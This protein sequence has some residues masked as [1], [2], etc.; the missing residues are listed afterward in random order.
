MYDNMGS[1]VFT[2]ACCSGSIGENNVDE[3]VEDKFNIRSSLDNEEPKMNT[4]LIVQQQPVLN[5]TWSERTLP[6]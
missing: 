4:P 5:R 2:A 3:E 6:P 1:L